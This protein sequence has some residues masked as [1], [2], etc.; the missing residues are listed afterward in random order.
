MRLLTQEIADAGGP[1]PGAAIIS[2]PD[3]CFS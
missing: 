3:F 2:I 1:K